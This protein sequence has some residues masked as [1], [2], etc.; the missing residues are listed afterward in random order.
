MPSVSLWRMVVW[1]VVSSEIEQVIEFFRTRR[2]AERM[3]AEVVRDEPNWQELFY[4]APGGALMSVPVKRGATWTAGTP[5]KLIET[6]YFRGGG[7]NDSRMY[8]VSL[9]GKRFL[10]IKQDVSADQS[11]ARIVV[12]QHWLEELKRLVPTK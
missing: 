3:L 9:D 7:G 4:I 10:M 6:V 11:G 12:V 8:D 2:E 1:G 5:T